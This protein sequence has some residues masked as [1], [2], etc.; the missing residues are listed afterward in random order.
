MDLTI[1]YRKN[2]LIVIWSPSPWGYTNVMF[3]NNNQ[4]TPLCTNSVFKC[5]SREF[6]RRSPTNSLRV[7]YRSSLVFKSWRSEYESDDVIM[8]QRSRREPDKTTGRC[9]YHHYVHYNMRGILM[10]TSLLSHPHYIYYHCHCDI[11][12]LNLAN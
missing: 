7:I 10:M 9:N 4:A 5:E 2:L 12:L 8:K 11:D 3:Y 1:K 6:W